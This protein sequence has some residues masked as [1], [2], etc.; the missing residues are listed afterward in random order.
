MIDAVGQME[1]SELAFFIGF[2]LFFVAPLWTY[3][4][5]RLASAA[6]FRSRADAERRIMKYQFQPVGTAI[7][8]GVSNGKNS[9]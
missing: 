1:K 7:Q 9:V 2:C 3:I 8:K 5:V 4:M 6:Y